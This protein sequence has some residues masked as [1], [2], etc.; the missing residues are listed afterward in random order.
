MGVRRDG[1]I[2]AM[3]TL[4]RYDITHAPLSELLDYSWLDDQYQ[5]TPKK[6]LDFAS[7]LI[8]GCINHLSKID[9]VISRHLLHWDMDRLS[10]VDLSVLRIGVYCLVYEPEIP[11]EVTINESVAVAR[12][13]SSEESFRFVNGV[14]DSILKN[15][16]KHANH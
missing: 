1:R 13:Y 3:Q 11:A 6:T 2:I 14:L 16:I 9:D 5:E 8:G 10:R 7:L 4:Y 15:E 12:E